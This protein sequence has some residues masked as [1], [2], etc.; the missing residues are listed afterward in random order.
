[1]GFQRRHSTAGELVAAQSADQETSVSSYAGLSPSHYSVLPTGGVVKGCPLR[2]F[3][4]LLCPFTTQ[5]EKL[6]SS[7]PVAFPLLCERLSR[8]MLKME[9]IPGLRAIQEFANIS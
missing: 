9:R 1:M 5:P 2:P 3:Y 8:A 6:A 4:V 7:V